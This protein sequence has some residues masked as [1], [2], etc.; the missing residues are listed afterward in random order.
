MLWNWLKS[1][2]EIKKHAWNAVDSWIKKVWEL[3]YSYLEDDLLEQVAVHDGV[4]TLFNMA[5]QHAKNEELVTFGL[6]VVN[7]II[8]N[9]M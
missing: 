5:S 1:M 9:G 8:E 7:T 2:R 6:D 4:Q 3:V